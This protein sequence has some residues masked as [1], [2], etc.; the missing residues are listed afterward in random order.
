MQAGGT[1]GRFM[2]EAL[3]TTGKHTVTALTRIDSQSK[4][5][6]GVVSKTIDYS[7]PETLVDALRG[8]DVLVI[9]LSAQSPKETEIQLINAAGEAGVAWI[10]PNDWSSDTTNEA[11]VRD[12]PI[13]QSKGEHSYYRVW[14]TILIMDAG[15]IR[16]EIESLGK[17]SYIAIATGFW[18]EWTLAMPAT[19]GFDFANRSVTFF[20]E[21]EVKMSVST[22]QQV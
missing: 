19:F 20:D 22:L 12:V 21:G 15:V 4:L 18:Y 16:K 6:E 7:K 8:Q 11:M 10:I 9:T 17:S 14:S 13:F 3:V 1:S 5:P 2:T